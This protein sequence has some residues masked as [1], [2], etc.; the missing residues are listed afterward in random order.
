M[1]T[2]HRVKTIKYANVQQPLVASPFCVASAKQNGRAVL[3]GVQGS[4]DIT[5][6]AKSPSGRRGNLL[7]NLSS[8]GMT[9]APVIPQ[10]DRGIYTIDVKMK[11]AIMLPHSPVVADLPV[12]L[13]NHRMSIIGESD[14]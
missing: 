7:C 1:N 8:S 2:L 10:L 13:I 11:E 6:I 12:R 3:Y 14:K 5:V 4:S 9:L